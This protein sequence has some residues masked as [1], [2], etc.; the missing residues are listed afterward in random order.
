MSGMSSSAPSEVEGDRDEPNRKY[1]AGGT[2]K[3][4]PM[5]ALS[6]GPSNPKVNLG[7]EESEPIVTLFEG[8]ETNEKSFPL[9]PDVP[10]AP[11]DPKLSKER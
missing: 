10:L 9:I 6:S 1:P 8:T 4:P 5:P 2:M 11:L 7:V 3:L